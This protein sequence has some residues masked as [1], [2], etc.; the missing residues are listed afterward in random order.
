MA[1]VLETFYTFCGPTKLDHEGWAELFTTRAIL[2]WTGGETFLTIHLNRLLDHNVSSGNVVGLFEQAATRVR[3]V[4]AEKSPSSSHVMEEC[5]VGL[6][7]AALVL[8]Y[9][10]ANLPVKAIRKQLW[11]AP[12]WPRGGGGPGLPQ[13]PQQ[14]QQ[15]QQQPQQQQFLGTSTVESFLNEAIAILS[16]YPSVAWEHDV[17]LCCCN[18]LL[19]ACSTQ[20][21]QID[22]LADDLFLN[23]IYG[24]CESQLRFALSHGDKDVS[25]TTAARLLRGLLLG[26][27]EKSPAPKGSVWAGL[28]TRVERATATEKLRE[29]STGSAVREIFDLFM[30]LFRLPSKAALA[31]ATTY[32]PPIRHVLQSSPLGER[33]TNILIILLSNRRSTSLNNPLRECLHLLRDD[34]LYDGD[35]SS[36]L[37]TRSLGSNEGMTIQRRIHVDMQNLSKRLAAS[38]PNDG[39]VLLLYSLLQHPTFVEMLSHGKNVDPILTSVLK[40]MY[41]CGHYS[42]EHLYVLIVSALM[43]IQDSSVRSALS[44]TKA[45]A[46]WYRERILSESSMCDLF[47]LC[48]LRVAL[49]GLFILQDKYLLTNCHALLLNL[50]PVVSNVDV[51]TAERLVKVLIQ[52]CKRV[53]REST[54]EGGDTSDAKEFLNVLMKFAGTLLR[55]ALRAGNVQLIYALLQDHDKV[56]D[57]FSSPAVLECIVNDSQ[58][59][60][61]CSVCD[62]VA[63][64]KQG[65][66]ALGGTSSQETEYFSAS[67]AVEVLS[68]SI[69]SAAEQECAADEPAN[70]MTY[71]YVETDQPEAFF[72][73][74]AW[75]ICVRVGGEIDWHLPAITLFDACPGRGSSGGDQ[76]DN[77]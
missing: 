9:F 71:S 5:C 42:L 4:S 32:A 70:W 49:H 62:I 40:G 14:Q 65:L 73:P 77:V 58:T 46:P 28:K 63:I 52:L 26:A 31:P 2:N 18:V 16:K 17:T 19:S 6:H 11:L 74:C 10:S 15:Q 23:Y 7:L 41:N 38:L 76:I 3:L 13:Q 54:A 57:L 12:D 27:V 44:S 29:N 8:N 34:N 51:Y 60:S 33:C 35:F 56:I 1:R 25:G 37:E 59:G 24:S 50:A 20:L 47:L 69:A 72:V 30:A 43:L 39:S 75:N 67:R 64:V 21:Y 55:P 36:D 53:V 45:N 22:R 48:S 68:E 66:A 61:S